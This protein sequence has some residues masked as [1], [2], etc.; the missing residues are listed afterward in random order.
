MSKV[1]ELKHISVLNYNDNCVCVNIAP[2]KSLCFDGANN[3]EP[4]MIP[5]TLDEIRFINNSLAFKN[6]WL[7]FPEDIEDELYDEL[8]IDKSKVLKLKEIK[9]ILLQPNKEGLIR[10]ISIQSLA[11]FDRVRAVFQ[12]LKSDGYR[13]TLDIANMIERRTK[14]LFNNQI[15]TNIIIDDAD[16]VT[17]GAKVKELEDQLARQSKEMAEMK[18][19]LAMALGNVNTN[20]KAESNESSQENTVTPQQVKK[21]GRP[22]KNI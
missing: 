8:R 15:K 11:D 21:P 20:A 17:N 6:G 14:E 9:E 22:K 7:E 10:I 4:T 19:M 16:V 18:E 3:G 2:G 1:T 13:L 5:L 12:K